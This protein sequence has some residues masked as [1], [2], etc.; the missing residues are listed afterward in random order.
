MSKQ[1]KT[2]KERKR[3]A[4]TIMQSAIEDTK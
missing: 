2:W 1:I 3:E 4:I